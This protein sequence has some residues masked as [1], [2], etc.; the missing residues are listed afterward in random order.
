M[1]RVSR[2]CGARTILWCIFQRLRQ[3]CNGLPVGSRHG[4]DTSKIQVTV[5]VGSILGYVMQSG[6]FS[7]S[8]FVWALGSLCAL[9]RL[10]FSEALLLQQ[11]PPP[12]TPNNLLTAAR[13]LG[14]KAKL[15]DC[16]L[17]KLAHQRFPL[18]ALMRAETA[19]QAPTSTN[20]DP[21][22]QSLDSPRQAPITDVPAHTLDVAII[23][24]CTAEE[25]TYFTPGT[26][27]PVKASLSEFGM[28]YAGQVLPTK[29]QASALKD[30]DGANLAGSFPNCSNIKK[31]GAMSCSP[32][33]FCNCS[34]SA[35]RSL[36]K[37]SLIKS[38]STAPPAR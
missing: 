11:T 10:P 29:P 3:P 24:A 32:R 8:S 36:P 9:H 26:Q 14:F 35:P 37:P 5:S 21:H 12:F 23:I 2:V 4:K 19:T 6:I 16:T 20:P 1:V 28:H 7:S 33:S 18:L 13:A 31:S 38:S 34:R 15:Q 25:I 17:Q 30:P 27:T 22:P